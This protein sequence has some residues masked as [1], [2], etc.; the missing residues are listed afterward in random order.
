MAPRIERKKEIHFELPK[1]KPVLPRTST[2][3]ASP[4]LNSRNLIAENK[5]F[6]N[7]QKLKLNN[8]FNTAQE[9]D[10]SALIGGTSGSTAAQFAQNEAVIRNTQPILIKTNSRTPA[11]FVTDVTADLQK[12]APGTQVVTAPI[13]PAA[14][15]AWNNTYGSDTAAIVKP[16]P[17]SQRTSAN[18]QGY[19]LLDQLTGN[20]NPVTIN[21]EAGNAFA[22]P[23]SIDGIG[24]VTQ[25]GKG[26][27]VNV[28]Y[29]PAL[30]VPLPS[31]DAKG[32]VV[33]SP[34]NSAIILGHEL[35]HASHMQRGTQQ[36]IAFNPKTQTL[37][38]IF[39]TQG[40]ENIINDGGRFY[41]EGDNLQIGLREEFR[42]VGFKGHRYGSEPT[43]NS[44]RRE[45]GITE[46]RASYQENG[47]YQYRDR[48]GNPITINGQSGVN[49]Y[50]PVSPNTA[51]LTELSARTQTF[52][53]NTIDG[54]RGSRNS[55][56]LGGGFNAVSA[57]YQGKDTQG[58][59]T[60]TAIGAGTGVGGE[61]IERVVNGARSTT[62]GM[63]S[64]S[65][66]AAR[67]TLKGAAVAGA[68]INTG[69]A[70]YEQFDNLQNDA[71][72]SQAVGTI[73]GEAVVGAASGA[74][75]AYTGAMAG[76]AIGSIVP[77]VG[78]VVGAVVG[79]AVGAAVGYLADKG[80]RELGVNTLVAQGV[81]AAYDGV[82]NAASAVVEGTK[83]FISGAANTLSSIFG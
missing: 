71:T 67:A 83:S 69:F 40:K 2:R 66:Q 39:G 52:R 26:T 28:F 38:D 77:G 79:F 43:E 65:F 25:P 32:N 22:Q 34:A 46:N 72:R 4:I 56:I 49:G 1:P 17:V 59:L 12:L 36:N 7:Q 37:T 55:A 57:L 14:R 78:T 68:V 30:R 23:N 6:G 54:F 63:T 61:V 50:N 16:A 29:D 81:T 76:A 51:R 5:L 15:V 3:P 44:L 82:S 74:A 27:G 8:I 35:G 48:F 24:S 47:F 80:L 33:K 21:Y 41:R 64:G 62:T 42:N 10:N 73:A 45:Q 11:N 75:G 9:R 70:V 60:D 18:Q 53:D 31:I 58:V 20:S 19:R 13:D